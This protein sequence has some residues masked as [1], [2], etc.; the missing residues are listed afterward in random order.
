MERVR[1]GEGCGVVRNT[2]VLS[3]CSMSLKLLM[4]RLSQAK[5]MEQTRASGS[6]EIQ[7]RTINGWDFEAIVVFAA[8]VKE[9]WHPGR[10]SREKSLRAHLS[11]C[12]WMDE[13]DRK[14]RMLDSRN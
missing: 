8:V 14:N 6:S 4:R 13:M 10:E 9:A 2:E 12:G 1:V 7:A 5:P 11:K 3:Q